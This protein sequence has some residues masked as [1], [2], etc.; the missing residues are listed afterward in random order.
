MKDCLLQLT[1]ISFLSKIFGT[2]V[3]LI[4]IVMCGCVYVCVLKCVDVLVICVLV[5]ERKTNLMHLLYIFIVAVG[6]A[7][8]NIYN[9]YIKLVFLSSIEKRCTVSLTS[10]VYLYLLCS[11][12]VLCFC[13][14][15]FM[16]M[17]SYLFCLY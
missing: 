10:N 13:I 16:Y 8:I 6:D 11:V 14:V 4:C 3:V 15:S 2:E 9:R 5:D 17:Y 7:T 1:D 12:F